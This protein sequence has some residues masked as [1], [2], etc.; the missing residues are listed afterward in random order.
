VR[1]LR[2]IPG[3]L[4][5]GIACLAALFPIY[6]TV[7]TSVKDRVDIFAQPPECW[8]SAPTWANYA[9]V[10][11]DPVFLRAAAVTIL[12]TLAST[13]LV[14]LAGALAANGLARRGRFAGRG[15]FDGMLIL[16]RALPGIVLAVPLYKIVVDLGVYDQPA[17]L[18]VVYA[19]INLPFAVWL[20]TGFVQGIPYELEE[21]AR[22]D[23]AN[24]AGV[25]LRVVLPLIGPGLAA[26]TIF[27][28]LMTWNEFLIPL[29]PA[30]RG[31]KTLP[32]YVGGFVTSRVIN[33]GAMAAA[34]IAILPIAVLTTLVQR[35][36]VRGLSSGAIKDQRRGERP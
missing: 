16:I 6:W 12:V 36:L 20:M 31:A 4:M 26:T 19:A 29:V 15:S 13:V 24:Q 30:D 2:T 9:E 21:A 28:A 17:A 25:L 32:V 23:G 27:V 10:L 5:L 1:T 14:T 18:V 33:W 34:S 35:N 7:L 11:A 3:H 8:V 22:V